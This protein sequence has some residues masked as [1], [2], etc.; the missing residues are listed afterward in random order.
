MFHLNR[1]I[2][3]LRWRKPST[4][5]RCDGKLRR[6][7]YTSI[8]DVRESCAFFT[9]YIYFLFLQR[10]CVYV[11]NIC[12]EHYKYRKRHYYI[13]HCMNCFDY[14]IVLY[15][16]PHRWLLDY[17]AYKNTPIHHTNALPIATITYNDFHMRYACICA[18]SFG[19]S[20]S[21]YTINIV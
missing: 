14:E 15:T 13:Y 18:R 7:E 8:Y 3:Q 4:R 16:V 9:S 1:T 19:L 10:Q 17:C 2:H 20:L 5:E 6:K 11:S 21:S 12:F